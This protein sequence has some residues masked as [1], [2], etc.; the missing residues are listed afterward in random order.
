MLEKQNRRN[1]RRIKRLEEDEEDNVRLNERIRKL[2]KK[3]VLAR[4]EI[5]TLKDDLESANEERSTLEEQLE[6]AADEDSLTWPKE[7]EE[8]VTNG[9][10]TRHDSRYKKVKVLLV[11]W[12]SDDLKVHKELDKLEQVFTTHYDYKVSRYSIPDDEPARALSGRVE[13]FIGDSSPTTLLIFCY[14][15]HGTISKLR[16][17]HNW[18]A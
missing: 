5:S 13:K 11:R 8:K 10:D 2:E 18:A 15:G 7:I 9:W 6:S 3:L 14:S 12:E 17:D 4:N 16:R 1:N